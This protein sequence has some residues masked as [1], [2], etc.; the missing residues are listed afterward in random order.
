MAD[1]GSHRVSDLS[2]VFPVN[3]AGGTG[4]VVFRAIGKDF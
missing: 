2:T 4:H 1:P 3:S